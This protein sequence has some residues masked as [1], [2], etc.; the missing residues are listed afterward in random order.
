MP[1]APK[2]MMMLVVTAARIYER[3]GMDIAPGVVLRRF[4]KRRLARGANLL[5]QSDR[6]TADRTS[7]MVRPGITSR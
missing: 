2:N 4:L 6:S 7:P 5:A 3:F 1:A